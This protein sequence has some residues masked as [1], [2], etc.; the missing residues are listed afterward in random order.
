MAS[1]E[2]GPRGERGLQG[3]PGP[4]G[5]SGPPGPAGPMGRTGATGATQGHYK[6]KSDKLRTQIDDLP[7]ALYG[8]NNKDQHRRF[9]NL[10]SYQIEVMRNFV[11]Y[12]HLALEDLLRALLFDFLIERNRQLTTKKAIRIVGDLRSADLVDWCGRLA[13]RGTSRDSQQATA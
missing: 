11:F 2:K 5:P 1:H 7:A 10:Q 6:R 9:L 8:L 12:R 4:P 13:A 3:I